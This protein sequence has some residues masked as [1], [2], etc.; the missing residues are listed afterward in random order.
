MCVCAVKTNFFIA[1]SAIS[2]T[3]QIELFL[4]TITQFTG[5]LFFVFLRFVMGEHFESSLQ[6]SQK[7]LSDFWLPSFFRHRCRIF[8]LP[9]AHLFMVFHVENY[10]GSVF[11]QRW[12]KWQRRER[13][14][15]YFAECTI[16]I[17]EE[18]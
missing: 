1:L 4:L 6:K 5:F 8:R 9:D 18:K 13:E 10:Y 15:R 14:N 7:F 12:E 2:N 16:T 17:Y 3:E 11:I